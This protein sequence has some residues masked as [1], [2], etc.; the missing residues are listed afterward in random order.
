M[1]KLNIFLFLTLIACGLGIVTAR[2]E[3]RK[4]F[5]A[6]EKEQKLTEQLNTEWDQLQ[7]EQSTL[8]MHARVEKIARKQLDMVSPPAE[9]I[10]VLDTSKITG[11][12][13]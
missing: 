11:L 12:S 5:M 7:L 1:I 10:L 8:A 4:I 2:H 3:A 6:Q 9:S 13:R